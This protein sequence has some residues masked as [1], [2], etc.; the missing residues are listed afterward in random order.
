MSSCGCPNGKGLTD[1]ETEQTAL[2]GY[3]KNEANV[4]AV[5]NEEYHRLNKARFT[6]MFQ[7]KR[8]TTFAPN[9]ENQMRSDLGTSAAFANFVSTAKK[10]S[11]K[12]QQEKAVRISQEDLLDQLH[13]C[14]KEFRYWSLRA[15]RLRLNQPEAYIKSS[16]EKIATLIRAGPFA[17]NYKLNDEYERINMEAG[18]VKEE[19][20]EEDGVSDEDMKD[21][22][23]DEG[24]DDF[25]DVTMS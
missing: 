9:V 7:P 17:M 19:A 5:E 3:I 16:L 22:D 12:R 8:T 18:G 25:E 20:A 21:E 23:G 13:Q 15:L 2:A 14:F 24:M 11:K 1:K 4:T 6:E 10:P